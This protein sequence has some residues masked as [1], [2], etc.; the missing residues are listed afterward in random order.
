MLFRAHVLFGM[1]V[2]FVLERFVEM[3]FF[4][5]GFVL[6]GSVF[7][8][9]DSCKSKA[10]RKAW[11]LSW[12]LKHRGFLH[13]LAGS[14]FFS[15]VVGVFSRWAGF[16][17]FVGYASHLLMDCFTRMGV[18]LFWPFSFKVRGFVKSGSWV[19]DVLFVLILGLDVLFV[20]QKL[21]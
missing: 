5:L 20:F 17:F 7:V 2:W 16:G 12:F 4:V 21:F 1:L 3:P 15:L 6:L 14:A 13:S 11:P 19:E 9:V 10:G 18:G 8:D